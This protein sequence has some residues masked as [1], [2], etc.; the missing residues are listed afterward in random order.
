MFQRQTRQKPLPLTQ[1]FETI[2]NRA[3]GPFLLLIQQVEG[4][5]RRQELPDHYVYLAAT[6]QVPRCVQPRLEAAA[7]WDLI[8]TLDCG[9]FVL[10]ERQRLGLRA[11]NAILEMDRQFEFFFADASNYAS[12]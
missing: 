8:W 6:T 10:L 9:K 5:F 1:T 12:S 2:Y 7:K 4:Q 3:T 11:P